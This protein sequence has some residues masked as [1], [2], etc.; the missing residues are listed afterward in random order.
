VAATQAPLYDVLSSPKVKGSHP[1][2]WTRELLKAFE[3]ARRVCPIYNS[4][5]GSE[6]K[7]QARFLQALSVTIKKLSLCYFLQPNVT[8]RSKYT[9]HQ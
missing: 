2:T 5:S 3:G 1:M 9:L 6:E 7:F 4:I 8:Y